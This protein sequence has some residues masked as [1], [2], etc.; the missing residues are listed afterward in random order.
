MGRNREDPD[1]S[2]DPKTFVGQFDES[3]LRKFEAWL[4]RNGYFKGRFKFDP[5]YVAHL[6]SHHGGVPRKRCFNTVDGVDKVVDRFLHFADLENDNP[7]ADYAVEQ[8]WSFASDRFGGFLMPFAILFAGD[9]LCF[10]YSR[11]GRPRIVVWFH[12]QSPPDEAPYT[13]FVAENFD[14]FLGKLHELPPASEQDLDAD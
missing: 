13:E 11:P 6:K 3:A 5:S 10:D 2:Y 12:E 7:L 9:M 8:M 4:N 14:E 1:L